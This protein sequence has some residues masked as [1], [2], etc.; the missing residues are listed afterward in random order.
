VQVIWCDKAKR[1]R[2]SLHIAMKP[3]ITEQIAHGECNRD[4]S[5]S[6]EFIL[7]CELHFLL[8]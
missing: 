4:M 1:V 3:Y 7:N 5:K 8:N 2:T 6:Q